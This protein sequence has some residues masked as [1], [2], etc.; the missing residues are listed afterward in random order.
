MFNC[1]IFVFLKVSKVMMKIWF[2]R[3]RDFKNIF[4]DSK[5]KFCQYSKKDE[6]SQKWSNYILRTQRKHKLY[7]S[8]YYLQV[9]LQPKLIEQKC[10]KQNSKPSYECSKNCRDFVS[11]KTVYQKDFIKAYLLLLNHDLMK[12]RL[13]LIEIWKLRKFWTVFDRFGRV[14]FNQKIRLLWNYLKMELNSFSLWH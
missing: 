5:K 8:K 10:D 4:P 9:N 2:K 13:H 7:S 12:C 14:H 11:L 6:A 1:Y 3:L